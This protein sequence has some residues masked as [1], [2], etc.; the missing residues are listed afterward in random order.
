MPSAVHDEEGGAGRNHRAGRF[1]LVDRAERIAGA[2]DEERG[3]PETGEVVGA[4]R[5][6]LARAMERIGQEQKRLDETGMRRGQHARLTTAVRDPAETHPAGAEAAYGPHRMA[7]PLA[8]SPG[9]RG[10]R[11]PRRTRLTERQIAAQHGEA[12]RRERRREIDEKRRLGVAA[13]AV[14]EDETVAARANRP[15]QD[16]ENGGKLGR[17]EVEGLDVRRPCRS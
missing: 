15:M 5:L 17:G 4:E 8:I 1:Q 6:R 11:R 12:C 13:G 3:C 16:A 14:G 9:C 2:V 10:R 7:Q